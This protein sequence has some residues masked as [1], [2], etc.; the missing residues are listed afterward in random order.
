MTHTDPRAA[1]DALAAAREPYLIGVRHHSPALA[2][3]VPALLDASGADVVCVELPADFQPWLEHL[4]DPETV[5]PVALAG[6]GQGGRLAFYPFADFSPELA[7]IRWAASHGATVLCCDLPLS[8]RGWTDEAPAQAAHTGTADGAPGTPGAAGTRTSSDAAAH[9]NAVPG[10]TGVPVS[11]TPPVMRMEAGA[12]PRRDSARVSGGRGTPGVGAAPSAG[13]GTSRNAAADPVAESDT[14]RVP[15]PGTHPV[16]GTRTVSGAASHPDSATAPGPIGVPDTEPA[17][18]IRTAA[19]AASEPGEATAGAGNAGSGLEPESASGSGLPAGSEP[20]ARRGSFA[21]ALTAAGTGRDG[22]DLWDRAVEVHAPGCSPDAVRRA[23]LGVGWALRADATAVPATDLA[24]EAHMRSVISGAVAAGHRVAAVIGAFH[25]PALPGTAP[26]STAADPEPACGAVTALAANPGSVP[27]T[28]AGAGAASGTHP[29]HP[30]GRPAVPG[31][32]HDRTAASGEPLAEDPA[33]AADES[34]QAGPASTAAPGSGQAPAG[35]ARTGGEPSQAEGAR[36]AA[37]GSGEPSRAGAARAGGAGSG[38]G[39]ADVSADRAVTSFVP[40]SFDL[41]DSRSGYPAGIRDPL[42]QQAVLEA[43]GD[44]ARVREAASV[45]LVRLCRELRRAGHTAGTGEA[46]E[47]LRLACDL[48]VLRGLP[49]PGRGELLEAVTTVL[50]QGEPLGR[51][52]ALA[53]A[54]EAVFVGTARGRITPHAPRSGL[55]PSVEAE[56][57][58]LRLPGPDEPAAREIRLDPLRSALDGRREVLLQRLLVCGAS[59]G[60]PLT[61]AATGDGTALGTKWRLSWTPSVP[62]RL[63]LAGV[64]GVTAAQAAAG[65][66]NDTARRAAADGGP[67]PAQILAGLGAAARCDLPAL[68]DVRLH[69]AATVL[70]QTATLPELLDAV[71]LLEALHRGHLP[72]TSAASRAASA[73]LTGDLLEAAVRS[74]PGLAGSDDPADAAALVALADRAAAHHLGLRTDDALASLAASASP[75]MQGAALAV[76]VLLDLDAAAGLGSRAAGWIDGAGTADSRRALTRRLAGLLTAAG[77]LLQSSPAALTPLLD[78]VEHLADQDFLD[79]L[80]ALRGGFDALSPAARDRLLDT[81]TERLGDRLDLTLDASPA[82]LA[83]WAAADAAGLAALKALPLPE[84]APPAPRAPSGAPGV[85]DAPATPASETPDAPRPA[86]PEPDGR[87]LAPADRWR[88]LLGRERDR[89]PAGA[90]RYAHALDELYGAGRGEGAGDL[91]G[92]QGPGQ[93]GGQDASFPTAREWSQ[94]LEAL[95]GADVREEVLA[96][97][98]E[99]GRTDVL[100][101]LDPAAVRPSMELLSS[102]LSLAG[103]LPEA[104]LAAL[105]PLVRRLVDELAKELATRLRPALSGLAT[106]RPTRRPGGRLDLDR[107]LRANLAHTRRRADG[108]VVV[109]PERPV[110]STRASREADWRLI[111]VVDVSGSMEASVIWSALTAAVLGGVPTLSTHF[112]AFSTQVVDLTDRVDDPL[113]LLLEVR[114]GGGT[115]IAAGLAHARSLITVPSRTL[116][117]VVSDFEEGAPIGGLLGEVR[118]LAASGAHLLGCAALD[119]AGT[120]RYS[121]PVARQLVAAGMPVAALSPLALARWVGDRLRGESR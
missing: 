53:R 87:R 6:T 102:V 59:Y 38:G 50:G 108:T 1:V 69:E 39:G 45:A 17:R 118:A 60:E 97:A 44:P 25:A 19:G 96:G 70:P 107:T 62:A 22:D 119:D 83:L 32:R 14:A 94:E 4:A 92:G 71:D 58:G 117:V 8:D 18:G 78:R 82:L 121:V 112:L 61:V 52:R 113:S 34:S 68:V 11:G 51:G 28:D 10:T 15:V 64:R 81:V 66:L 93:G 35:D 63:D 33:Q 21:D 36:T 13:A 100:A 20:E 57:T 72:G 49:A 120:P 54:L 104:R 116:V 26:G 12:A 109:V 73:A 103:G 48:A 42:W 46:A 111:L 2:A 67:T 75:L 98:A 79:R 37:P 85:P 84:T 90:R 86:T 56:L 80:P 43:G 115:H 16:P 91:G 95:F 99:A 47:T 110:F 74:L 88:L 3:V 89:L 24:R 76:R 31:P 106:P 29:D 5:A 7:A 23:A 41:L 77:P 105:R 65:T 9:P 30:L 27:G 114:V 101:Q 40:Y 55:G